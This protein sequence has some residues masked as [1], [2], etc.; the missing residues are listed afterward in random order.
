MR[1]PTNVQPWA[2]N[3]VMT[4]LVEYTSARAPFSE[5][6]VVSHAYTGDSTKIESPGFKIALTACESSWL[7]DKMPNETTHFV[8]DV[9]R[10]GPNT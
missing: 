5:I 10:P 6:Q 2:L 8:D 9:L 3:I 1:V 4:P 7:D